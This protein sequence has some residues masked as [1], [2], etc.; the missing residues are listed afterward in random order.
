MVITRGSI[1]C[2]HALL[3][4]W[5]PDMT[6]GERLDWLD[7]GMVVRRRVRLENEARARTIAEHR[8]KLLKMTVEERRRWVERE[9]KSR[10]M[11][12]HLHYAAPSG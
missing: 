2:Y 6:P 12:S 10:Q 5:R 11:S 9:V 7:E 1:R 3:K 4:R 8:S